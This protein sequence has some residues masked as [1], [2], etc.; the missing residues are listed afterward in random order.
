MQTPIVCISHLRWD[1]VWQRPQHILSRMAAHTPVYFVEEPVTATDLTAPVLD[2]QPQE[3]GVTV[4]RLRIP[5]DQDRWIGHGDPHTA[6]VYQQRVRD[7][8]A[9]AG[10]TDTTL[11]LYTPMGWHFAASIPHS[12][13]VYDVMD[14]LSAFKGAPATLH[15]HEID[16]LKQA[17]VVFTGGVSLYQAKRMHKPGTYLFPSGVD[18]DHFAP[19]ANQ[20]AFRRPAD[21]PSAFT[22]PIFGYY[23][24]IDERFDTTLI[25]EAAARR[26]AWQFVFIGPVVKIDPAELPHAPN[27]HYIGMRT[28]DQLPEYLAH[29]DVALVPFAIN[30]A[31]RYLSPTKTLEYMAAHKPIISTPIRDV[32]TL[33]GSVV[34]IAADAA[35][36]IEAGEA[37]LRDDG[38]WRL[39][40]ER[41]LLSQH[42]WDSVV[43]RMT[44]IIE[45]QRTANTMYTGAVYERSPLR[46]V[47]GDT[48]PL[49]APTKEIRRASHTA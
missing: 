39:S 28:Y 46:E 21:L 9:E 12:L 42:T 30:E 22:G 45:T 18:I 17:D 2:V 24:V 35:S 3:C 38:T 37:A 13:L 29:F 8:L 49:E 25:A 1:F 23:G 48:E 5:A 33:F 32:E 40:L 14:E 47:L 31:T 41:A 10:I 20:T 27:I 36:L 26:P 4:L 34:S 7:L 43:S 16:V 11:W 15:H 6:L 44:H 19:A